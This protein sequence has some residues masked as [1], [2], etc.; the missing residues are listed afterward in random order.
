MANDLLGVTE[1]Y[2]LFS[3]KARNLTEGQFIQAQKEMRVSIL[4]D[5]GMDRIKDLER[6]DVQPAA[7]L[8][9]EVNVTNFFNSI[10]PLNWGKPNSVEQ[11]NYF[12]FVFSNNKGVMFE[13]LYDLS[14]ITGYEYIHDLPEVLYS[15]NSPIAYKR[16]ILS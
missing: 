8:L 3:P 2:A 1:A 14:G 11:A 10:N 16:V 12:Q 4:K 6:V 13:V 15:P 9:D 7:P 5:V